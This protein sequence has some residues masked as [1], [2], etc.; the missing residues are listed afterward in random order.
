MALEARPGGGPGRGDKTGGG[1]GAGVCVWGGEWRGPVGA[2]DGA[3]VEVVEDAH[4]LLDILPKIMC[5]II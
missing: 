3:G 5:V 2:G 1:W 4:P